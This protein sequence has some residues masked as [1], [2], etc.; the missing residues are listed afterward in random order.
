MITTILKYI[1]RLKRASA[2]I[3]DRFDSAIEINNITINVNKS[4]SKC[5]YTNILKNVTLNESQKSQR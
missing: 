1:C 4:K 3:K 2:W 5:M